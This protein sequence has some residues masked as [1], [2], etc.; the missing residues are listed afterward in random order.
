MKNT[1]SYYFSFKSGMFSLCSRKQDVVAQSTAEPK[2]IA[3]T[4]VVN[5]AIWITKIL[6]D[7]HMD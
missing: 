1:S 6:A 2:Y 7:L 3:V 4:A 5:Q